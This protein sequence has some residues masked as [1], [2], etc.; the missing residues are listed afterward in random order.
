MISGQSRRSKKWASKA[1]A[2]VR[3][4]ELSSQ[5]RCNGSDGYLA[6]LDNTLQIRETANSTLSG[7]D[8]EFNIIDFKTL[9]SMYAAYLV[10]RGGIYDPKTS[11]SCEIP[12]HFEIEFGYNDV[13]QTRFLF[14]IPLPTIS[15]NHP[16]III[17]LIL[18][19]DG[20]P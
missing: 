3:E 1:G 4:M 16:G 6:W 5:F 7:A 20:F 14:T 15:C 10:N 2:E 8:Y 13:K 17:N 9:A 18:S 12:F 19:N 11:I